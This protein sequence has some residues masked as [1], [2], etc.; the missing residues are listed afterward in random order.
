MLKKHEGSAVGLFY[1]HNLF[2]QLQFKLS[3]ALKFI[4]LWYTRL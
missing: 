3:M 4:G 2:H 1:E